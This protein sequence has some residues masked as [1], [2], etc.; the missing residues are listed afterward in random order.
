MDQENG[1]LTASQPPQT[2]LY[3]KLLKICKNFRVNEIVLHHHSAS[4]CIALLGTQEV[5]VYFC[6]GQDVESLKRAFILTSSPTIWQ[7]GLRHVLGGIQRE[8][9]FHSEFNV[10]ISSLS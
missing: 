1:V 10:W 5:V 9:W 4:T 2:Y 3:H 8:T 6:S 7:Y